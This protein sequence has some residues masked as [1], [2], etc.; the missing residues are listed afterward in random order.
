MHRGC[1]DCREPMLSRTWRQ[2]L[3]ALPA[4]THSHK[5]A[6]IMVTSL[7]QDLVPGYFVL[8]LWGTIV[9]RTYGTDKPIY[10]LIFT[11]NIWSY[12]L[13]SPVIRRVR[14]SSYSVRSPCCREQPAVKIVRGCVLYYHPSVIV[15]YGNHTTVQKF[16]G[17]FKGIREIQKSTPHFFI[18]VPP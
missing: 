5:H 6:A 9:N 16:T 12:L 11:N 2:A 15:S 10:F 1:G 18:G 14:R 3:Q 8:L 4:R 17:R 7:W 13:W